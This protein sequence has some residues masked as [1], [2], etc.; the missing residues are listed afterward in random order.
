MNDWPAGPLPSGLLIMGA[1]LDGRRVDVRIRRGHVFA[2]APRLDREPSEEVI[3]AAGGALL[4]GLH[5][6]HVH[7]L[8]L[9]AARRS[10]PAGPPA[11]RDAG[12][13]RAALTRADQVMPAGN[14]LR[15]VGYHESVAGPLDRQLLDGIVTDRPVRV[16]HRSGGLWI[17]NSAGLRAAG[18]Q[19]VH[20]PDVERDARG[21]LTGRL[22]RWDDRLRAAVGDDVVPEL[23]ELSGELSRLGITG[24]TDATPDLDPATVSL[25]GAAVQSA[26]LAQRLVLLGAPLGGAQ[27]DGVQAGPVKLLLRD[28]DLPGLPALTDRIAAAHGAGRS[29]AVHCVTRE[30]LL[31]TLAALE[32][33][34]HRPG[35][36]IE[37][38]AIVPP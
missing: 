14:W 38:A 19:T 7:L 8:A 9:D 11:V 30:S 36:R 24:V 3:P 32:D 33:A 28:H 20:D 34:G 4:P 10:T 37:L 6:H 35:D 26:T 27:P 18:L 5:D 13:L 16:Q 22:W 12:Q 2:I 17:L 21:E 31:L 23:R 15:A 25:F 29:V 1:E